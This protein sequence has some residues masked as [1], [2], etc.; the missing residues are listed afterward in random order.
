MMYFDN[1]ERYNTFH[2]VSCFLSVFPCATLPATKFCLSLRTLLPCF[3]IEGCEVRCF[4]SCRHQTLRHDSC[5]SRPHSQSSGLSSTLFKEK[6]L[7]WKR[8]NMLHF[9]CSLRRCRHLDCFCS[10]CTHH[11]QPSCQEQL[12]QAPSYPDCPSS[13]ALRSRSA[14]CGPCENIDR[15][16]QKNISSC[17]LAT[18]YHSPD[19]GPFL[20]LLFCLCPSCFL[21]VA[22]EELF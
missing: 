10:C 21:L 4:S 1:L 20:L 22:A 15:T 13:P 6:I 11:D 19:F 16:M 8:L 12:G 9:T 5:H 18:C 3:S 14:G 7:K 2:G 17:F